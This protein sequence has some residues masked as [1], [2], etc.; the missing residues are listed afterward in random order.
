[1]VQDADTRQLEEV[2]KQ[3]PKLSYNLMRLVN[4][5]SMGGGQS[6]ISNF[7]QAITRL[8]RRQLQRWL[9]LLIYAGQFGNA[10][11]NPLMLQA[12]LRGRLLDELTA[13]LSNDSEQHDYG[14]M[15]GIF[16]LLDIQLGIRMADIVTALPLNAEVHAALINRQGLFGELLI[17]V[18]AI[19]QRDF[20]TA[21]AALEKNG[22]TPEMLSSAQRTAFEW[23]SRLNIE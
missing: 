6:P 4:S 20:P 7:G 19:E 17:A 21:I 12:A 2:F 11:P 1:M 22:V 15:T 16:S 5:V 10:E 9:Q 23:V 8:G 14:F 13:K 3:E 18:E